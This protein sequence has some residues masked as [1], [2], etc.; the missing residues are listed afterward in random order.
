MSAQAL[1]QALALA[2]VLAASAPTWSPSRP[3]LP[4]CW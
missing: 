4:A 2:L 3:A 1:L